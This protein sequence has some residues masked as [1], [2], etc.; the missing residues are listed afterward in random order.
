MRFVLWY[1]IYSV[2][3]LLD[4]SAPI[5]VGAFWETGGKSIIVVSLGLTA[6]YSVLAKFGIQTLSGGTFGTSDT[7]E[8]FNWAGTPR[9]YA[10]RTASPWLGVDVCISHLFLALAVLGPHVLRSLWM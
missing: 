2:Y 6:F 3:N 7:V 9:S 10:I 8:N 1:L 4:L 5:S